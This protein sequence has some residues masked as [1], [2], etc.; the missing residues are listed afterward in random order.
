[1]DRRLRSRDPEIANLPLRATFSAMMTTEA[2]HAVAL[3]VG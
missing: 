2:E 1:V 3:A